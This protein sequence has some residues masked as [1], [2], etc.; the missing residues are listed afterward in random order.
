MERASFRYERGVEHAGL[1]HVLNR[2]RQKVW[3]A[4]TYE[5]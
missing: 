2:P 4:R 3:E 5:R 1:P